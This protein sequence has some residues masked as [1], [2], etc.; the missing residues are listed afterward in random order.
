MSKQAGGGSPNG[1]GELEIAKSVEISHPS[2]K[3]G[4]SDFPKFCVGVTPV[5]PQSMKIL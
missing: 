4:S 2:P 5:P 3:I 1:G